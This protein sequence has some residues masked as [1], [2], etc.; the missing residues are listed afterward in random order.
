MYK[1]PSYLKGTLGMTE[2]L[3]LTSRN[4]K[5]LGPG[6]EIA[7]MMQNRI[8]SYQDFGLLNMQDTLLKSLGIY[9]YG[10]YSGNLVATPF[11][12][13][14]MMNVAKFALPPTLFSTINEINDNYT[15]I[16]QNLNTKLL[17][18]LPSTHQPYTL[19]ELGNF[20]HV[21]KGLSAQMM[22]IVVAQK[23]WELL[24]DLS[25]ISEQTGVFVEDLDYQAGLSEDGK[26]I[27]S[28]LLKYISTTFEKNKKFTAKIISVLSLILNLMSIHQYYDFLK[29]KPEPA[30]KKDISHLEDDLQSYKEQLK[31]IEDK[32][33]QRN[34]SRVTN[35]QCRVMLK[36]NL[37]SIVITVL[38]MGFEIS[39][40]N[41]N[42]KW[43]YVSFI[44]PDDGLPQ[45]GW[46]LKKYTK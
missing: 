16:Y 4:L 15:R 40:L 10:W 38:P 25:K 23:Q 46:V 39:I 41:E 14:S 22:A 13:L 24:D 21:I 2:A 36:P 19:A 34:E 44:N 3:N 37:K 20:K 26:R 32:L 33:D 27:L 17:A 18:A 1:F 29:E 28:E 42:H 31:R 6:F 12:E 7:K 43:L 8:K 45:T 11:K 30:L 9:S 5:G 35:R